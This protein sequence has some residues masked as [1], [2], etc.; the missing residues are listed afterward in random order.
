[1]GAPPV[2]RHPSVRPVAPPPPPRPLFLS[3]RLAPPPK[4]RTPPPPPPAS[5]PPPAATKPR[6]EWLPRS[7]DRSAHCGARKQTTALATK[8]HPSPVS[9]A[10]GH[11][12]D[13]WPATSS[14]PGARWRPPLANAPGRP[15]RCSWPYASAQSPGRSR[16]DAPATSDV[17]ATNHST[18][19]ST[20]LYPPRPNDSLT[21]PARSV[22][23]EP[24]E[25]YLRAGS[26]A[27]PGSAR[28]PGTMSN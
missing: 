15:Q 7:I 25:A 9:T 20:P 1:A 23:Y 8:S 3:S 19:R 17:I 11:P 5:T 6:C 27:A 14:A 24:R 16:W 12:H 22:R 10:P 28:Q 18:A 2:R 4:G 13:G 21:C 26:D